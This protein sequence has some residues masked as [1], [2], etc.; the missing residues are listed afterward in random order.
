MSGWLPCLSRELLHLE[1]NLSGHGARKGQEERSCALS[2]RQSGTSPE[3][4]L[5]HLIHKKA[6][7]S[8][9]LR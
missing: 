6:F 4:E 3:S 1:N 7:L 9:Y 8:N 2:P 5:L